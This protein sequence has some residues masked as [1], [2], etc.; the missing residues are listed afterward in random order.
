M[1]LISVVVADSS[2]FV[3][4]LLKSYLESTPDIRVIG[5]A[6]NGQQ[7]VELVATEQ[8]D[9]ITLNLEM[10]DSSGL[11][12]L[13]AIQQVRPTPIII[14]SGANM[15]AASMSLEAL[16]YGAVDFVLKFTPG[17]TVDPEL[18]RQ[19][20]INKV[21]IA[22]QAKLSPL[23][24][25][26]AS[27]PQAELV[28]SSTAETKLKKFVSGLSGSAIEAQLLAR[29][30]PLPSSLPP[31]KIIVAGAS[32]G[33]PLALRQML[34]CLP[35]DFPGAILVVQH[36]PP[37]FT[38]VLAEQLNE[39]VSL[40]VK[41]AGDGDKLERATVLITPGW[42]H[43]RIGPD[44][45]VKLF[46][47]AEAG[48]YCPSINVT[49]QSAAEVFNSRAR[50]VLLTGMGEDGVEGMIAIRQNGGR[51]FAQDP[52]TCTVQGMPQRAIEAGVVDHIAPPEH[53]ARLLMMGY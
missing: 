6:T 19:D 14:I 35:E 2:P 16:N 7:I 46:S 43:L 39:Q 34:G 38:P 27:L 12:A 15:L 29:S 50:G 17:Q 25:I 47:G 22:A 40:R 41:E 4:R 20:I 1:K 23:P 21:R 42:T 51:T 49:M 28:F 3:C 36:L 10:S 53:I 8:P 18:L 44:G 31:D 13:I 30:K 24:Q 5:A 52:D 48:G 11:D 32:S 26:K 33:G 37:L 45:C 9:V